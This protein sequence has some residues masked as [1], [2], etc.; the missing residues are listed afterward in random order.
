MPLLEVSAKFIVHTQQDEDYMIWIALPSLFIC[1]HTQC[2]M[3]KRQEDNSTDRPS[4]IHAILPPAEEEIDECGSTRTTAVPGRFP[5]VSSS[6]VVERLSHENIYA[7]KKQYIYL[8]RVM[9]E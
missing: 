8:L 1:S 6:S 5:D 3:R 9:C 2:H 4:R 7:K